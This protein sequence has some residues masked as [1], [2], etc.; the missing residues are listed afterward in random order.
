MVAA[1]DGLRYL[2]DA[3]YDVMRDV[4]V[5]FGGGDANCMS[6]LADTWEFDGASWRRIRER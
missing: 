5:L 4:L 6:L 3:A 1:R 2:T